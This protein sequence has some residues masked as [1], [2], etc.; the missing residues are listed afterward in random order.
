MCV[1]ASL[2]DVLAIIIIILQESHWGH[3]FACLMYIYTSTFYEFVFSFHM[4]MYVY[5]CMCMSVR[6]H[7]CSQNKVF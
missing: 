2:F 7:V 5:V 4:C 3:V 1:C 6:V